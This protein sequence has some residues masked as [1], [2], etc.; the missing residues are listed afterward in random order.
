MHGAERANEKDP[1][2][3]D[4][5]FVGEF[6]GIVF[7]VSYLIYEFDCQN[8]LQYQRPRNPSVQVS[9]LDSDSCHQKKNKQ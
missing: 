4:T 7:F 5:N 1:S 2:T 8:Y 9:F 3:G 6:N